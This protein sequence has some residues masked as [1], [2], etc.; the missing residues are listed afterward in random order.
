MFLFISQGVVD[1]VTCIAVF[2]NST[3][4]IQKCAAVY[5]KYSFVFCDFKVKK[6]LIR[7]IACYIVVF[8][9]LT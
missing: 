7:G 5:R 2:A 8:L 3:L 4:C 1:I 6:K 9:I